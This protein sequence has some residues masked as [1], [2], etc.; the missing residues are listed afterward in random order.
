[1][2]AL[3]RETFEKF[4][5]YPSDLKPYSIKRILVMCDGCGK[6]REIQ[7]ASY[8]SLCKSCVKKGEK[9]P[10]YGKHHSD[11]TKKK[12]SDAGIGEKNHNFGQHR[13][14]ETRKKISKTKKGQ[15]PS[16]ETKQKISNAM[17]GEKN[18]KYGK[19]H[20]KETRKKISEVL[21]KRGGGFGGKHHS[22]ETLKKMS[23]IK[24][25]K[26]ASQIT[27]AKLREIRKHRK[28]PKHHTKPELIFEQICKKHNLPFK[29]TGDSTFWIHNIN[30]DFVECN[31]KK[32]AVEIFGDY[33]H[34]PLLNYKLKEKSTL[35]YRK[36][37]L[38]KYGWE[39][40]VLWESD[41]KREDV[42]D[43]V[44]LQLNEERKRIRE[45]QDRHTKQNESE[46]E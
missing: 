18:H 24:E 11:E 43:F 42:E 45:I 12:I 35:T 17:R 27:K 7:K 19:H 29:Y 32:I 9:N 40:I 38:K 46:M 34:S 26:K 15:H 25:R 4:G 10:F 20:S 14:K 2:A 16:E 6:I 28:I 39:L 36:K 33:W 22:A 37:I 3:E 1:M 8:R 23:D 30:P 44:L 41:L 31:G 21:K 5:Y 13:N